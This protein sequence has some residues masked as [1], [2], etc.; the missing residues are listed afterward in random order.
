MKNDGSLESSLNL[1]PTSAKWLAEIGI[2]T[3][4]ELMEVGVV[5]AYC[6]VKARQP[7]ASLNLLYAL[8]GAVHHIPWNMLPPETKTTLREEVA[9]FRFGE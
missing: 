7:R 3:R 8:Y 2:H 6:L 5:E 1:G 9:A 4:A